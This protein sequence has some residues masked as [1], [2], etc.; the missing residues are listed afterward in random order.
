MKILYSLV[1]SLVVACALQ[2]QDVVLQVYVYES[3]DRGFVEEVEVQLT[4]DA[5]SKVYTGVTNKDGYV[6]INVPKDQSF[7]LAARKSIFD[8]KHMLVNTRKLDGENKKFVKVELE[9]SPGYNFEVTMAPRRENHDIPV[10]AIK[11]A[12][13]EVYNNTTKKE[14]LNIKNHPKLEF[15]VHFENGNHYTIMIRKKGYFTKRMEAYV[16]VKGCIICFDGIGKVEPGVVDNLTDD[17]RTGVLLANVELDPLY[18]G[19]K[20]KVENLYYDYAKAT[21]RPRSKQSLIDLAEVLKDNPHIMVELGSHTDARGRAKKNQKLSERRAKSAVDYLVDRLNIPRKSIIAMGYGEQEPVNKCKDGVDC[22]EEQHQENRRT[23]IKILEIDY[24]K[25]PQQTLAQIRVEEEF[26]KQ[27][28]ESENFESKEIPAEKEEE[29]V[30]QM[31]HQDEGAGKDENWIEVNKEKQEEVKQEALNQEIKQEVPVLKEEQE[32]VS[33]APKK[34]P[35]RKVLKPQVFAERAA[36]NPADVRAATTNKALFGNYTGY[37]VV[38]AST[39]KP[40]AKSHKIFKTFR[41][42]DEYKREDGMLLYMVGD[43][44]QVESA[45]VFLNTIEKR[46]PDAYVLQF[47]NGQRVKK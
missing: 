31:E 7:K 41:N 33:E 39:K 38:V 6:E 17:N 20:F 47:V 28:F 42:L 11:G 1:L 8:T 5:T 3:G 25:V 44:K 21:L 10:D 32:T 2:A 9:R 23:E 34:K 14:V 12:W 45:Q 24:D 18:S 22:S 30:W 43:F 36:P 4:E 27:V 13:I 40:L 29:V 35:K 46:L 16:N 19:K 26:L 15:D 37:K